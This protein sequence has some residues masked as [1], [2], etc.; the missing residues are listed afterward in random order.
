MKNHATSAMSARIKYRFCIQSRWSRLNRAKPSLFHDVLALVVV[1]EDH[2]C[3]QRIIAITDRRKEKQC[4]NYLRHSICRDEVSGAECVNSKAVSY[5]TLRDND[6]RL[7]GMMRQPCPQ[8]DNV[9]IGNVCHVPLSAHLGSCLITIAGLSPE[10][11]LVIKD[12][13]QGPLKD[14]AQGALVQRRRL[15][16]QGRAEFSCQPPKRRQAPFQHCAERANDGHDSQ[17]D[18]LPM[19]GERGEHLPSFRVKPIHC[20]A[21][22]NGCKKLERDGP[23]SWNTDDDPS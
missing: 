12:K 22:R 1:G 14:K 10:R 3:G 18:L 11:L 7:R 8:N 9:S 4:Y 16:C 6:G 17:R 15:A 21:E 5:R 2:I 13:A 19:L 20:F 23:K